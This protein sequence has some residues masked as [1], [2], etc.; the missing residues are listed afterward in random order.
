MSIAIFQV[1]S[2]FVRVNCQSRD[3]LKLSMVSPDMPRGSQ[4]RVTFLGNGGNSN[5]L[6]VTKGD[7]S[8][9]DFTKVRTWCIVTPRRFTYTRERIHLVLTE[10][11]S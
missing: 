7:V 2:G 5:G 3:T 10:S 6:K 8:S 9:K 1:E 4:L 11:D